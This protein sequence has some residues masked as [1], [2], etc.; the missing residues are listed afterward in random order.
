MTREQQIELCRIYNNSDIECFEYLHQFC[1]AEQ[2]E[3]LD[4]LTTLNM[5]TTI[6]WGRE[7]ATSEEMDE[8]YEGKW[9]LLSAFGL[10]NDGGDAYFE[11][12]FYQ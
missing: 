6:G 2:M 11:G 1:N 3:L 5:E 8:Y 9:K 12:K 4:R 7:P 10:E